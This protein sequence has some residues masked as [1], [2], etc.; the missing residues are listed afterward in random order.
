MQK[1]LVAASLAA[2]LGMGSSAYAGDIYGGMKDGPLIA[3]LNTWAGFYFGINGGSAWSDDGNLSSTVDVKHCSKSVPDCQTGTGTG[4]VE[5][6]SDTGFGGGQFGYNWQH[7]K[8]VFGLEADIQ[9]A[10]E[11]GSAT[12]TSA[13]GYGSVTGSSSLDWYGTVRG[14]LGLTLLNNTLV[15]ATGGFAYGEVEDKL[16]GAFA[17]GLADSHT[18]DTTATGYVVGGGLEYAFSRTVSIKVEYQYMDLGSTSLTGGTDGHFVDPFAGLKLKECAWLSTANK[19]DADH[20]YS[21][22]RVG[23]NYHIAPAYEPLK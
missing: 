16:S 10:G 9:G 1:T 11:V 5:V 22:V 20:A 21:T 15:Y 7:G 23:L 17:S 2:V 3:P 6:N 18:S 12:L 14:R 19:L 13:S 4:S 8:V